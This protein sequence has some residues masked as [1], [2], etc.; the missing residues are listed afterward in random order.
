MPFYDKFETLCKEK[1][2]T[3]TG[4]AREMGITQQAVSLWKK[5]GSV[6]KYETLR[7]VA[8]YFGVTVEE[9][10]DLGKEYLDNYVDDYVDN[11]ASKKGLDKEEFKKRIIEQKIE[12]YPIDFY[13]NVVESAESAVIKN[14]EDITDKQLRSKYIECF[15]YLNRLGR[16]E[17][18]KRMEEFI[19]TDKYCKRHGKD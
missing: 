5:R 3:P 7:K 11:Y 15:Q 12:D 18:V 16:I 6:P 10:L 14:Y 9:L 2:I 8:D 1:G 13:L 19:E 4:A 17:A